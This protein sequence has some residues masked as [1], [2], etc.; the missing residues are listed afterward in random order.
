MHLSDE[1]IRE[2]REIWKREF[3]E[4]LTI[5]EARHHASRLLELYALLAK[6][7]PK[8]RRQR[9]SPDTKP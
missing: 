1:D 9:G 7:T 3:H 5:E 6:P 8:E 2:F 4:E